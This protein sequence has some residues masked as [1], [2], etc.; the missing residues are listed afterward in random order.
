MSAREDW[1]TARSLPGGNE[2]IDL[3]ARET[4]CVGRNGLGQDAKIS[5]VS[6]Q[7]GNNDESRVS[8]IKRSGV[9]GGIHM[10][11]IDSNFAGRSNNGVWRGWVHGGRRA[12]DSYHILKECI[13]TV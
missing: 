1:P 2:H 7:A 5:P 3:S 6:I 10:G 8:G 11:V 13:K 9:S 12:V 4:C